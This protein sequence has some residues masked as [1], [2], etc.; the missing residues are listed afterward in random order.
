MSTTNNFESSCEVC[1]SKPFKYTCP[2]CEILYCS[3]K[4]YQAHGSSCT[5]TFHKANVEAEL[6]AQ[7]PTE[8]ETH[9]FARRLHEIHQNMN[10]RDEA[11]RGDLAPLEDS[12]QESRDENDDDDDDNDDDDDDLSEVVE[13]NEDEEEIVADGVSEERIAVLQRKAERGELQFEDLTSVEMQLFESALKRGVIQKFVVATPYWW[14]H[15][16]SAVEVDTTA[17][18]PR[19]ICCPSGTKKYN[20][21]VL[22]S[23]INFL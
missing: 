20:P 23:A 9:K 14:Q 4:C 5:E 18:I 10:E 16:A 1:G 12:L 8:Q 17:E 21:L 11:A 13:G 6:A 22:H 7:K 2:K 19:H 3:L 15:A